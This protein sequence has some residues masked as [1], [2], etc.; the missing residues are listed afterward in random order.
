VKKKIYYLLFTIVLLTTAS[1]IYYTLFHNPSIKSKSAN[2]KTDESSI[3]IDLPYPF[4]NAVSLADDVDGTTWRGDIAVQ[5]ALFDQYGFNIGRSMFMYVP[6]I[7]TNA[8]SFTNQ[9]QALASDSVINWPTYENSTYYLLRRYYDGGINYIHMWSTFEKLKNQTAIIAKQH[10]S[11]DIKDSQH[12]ANKNIKVF[13]DVPSNFP[14]MRL[15]LTVN[16]QVTDAVVQIIDK[17]HQTF[18]WCIGDVKETTSC[19]WRS[20]LPLP[21]TETLKAI[22]FNHDQEKKAT[23]STPYDYKWSTLNFIINGQPGA[24]A[25]FSEVLFSA[26]N[27]NLMKRQTKLLKKLGV[28]FWMYSDHGGADYGVNLMEQALIDGKPEVIYPGNNKN[29]WAQKDESANII[30]TNHP[31]GAQVG[32]D[33]YFADL[34]QKFGSI[35]YLFGNGPADNYKGNIAGWSGYSLSELITP[36]TLPNGRKAYNTHRYYPGGWHE[37]DQGNP[38]TITWNGRFGQALNYIF[39]KINTDNSNLV[40]GP[41]ITHLGFEGTEEKLGLNVHPIK[42]GAPFN[43]T[44]AK[45][46]TELSNRFYNFSN[47]V[48]NTQRIWVTSPSRLYR[49]A[50]IHPA[51]KNHIQVN[52]NSQINITSWTDEVSAEQ[53]PDKNHI[54]RDLAGI[55]VY[56]PDS[57]SATVTV[58]DQD[59]FDFTRNPKDET[60]RES[61][62][63]TDLSTLHIIND[64]VW[65]QKFNN[66]TGS[67]SIKTTPDAPGSGMFL[68]LHAPNIKTPVKLSIPVQAINKNQHA[69]TNFS[70]W[71]KTDNPNAILSVAYLLE[72]GKKFTVLVR[73][74]TTSSLKSP[75]WQLNWGDTNQW[76]RYIVSFSSA[77]FKST[78]PIPPRGMVKAIQLKMLNANT[79]DIAQIAFGRDNPFPGL[80][81]NNL[82][83]G[84]I[85]SLEDEQLVTAH[86]KSQPD[87]QVKT[88]D[89]GYFLLTDIPENTVLTSLDVYLKSENRHVIYNTPLQIQSSIVDLILP[90]TPKTAENVYQKLYKNHLAWQPGLIPRNRFSG[91]RLKSES[92]KPTGQFQVYPANKQTHWAGMGTLQEYDSLQYANNLGFLDRKERFPSPGPD[93]AFN[94]L[95][96]GGCLFAGDQFSAIDPKINDWLE[97]KIQKQLHRP[98]EVP[99]FANTWLNPYSYN[100][101]YEQYGKQ[102]QPK[103]VIVEVMMSTFRNASPYLSAVE[104][105]LQLGAS[106][107]A[108]LDLNKDDSFFVRNADPSFFLKPKKWDLDLHGATAHAMSTLTQP[109]PWMNNELNHSTQII[110]ENLKRM[111]NQIALHGGQLVLVLIQD[112]YALSQ[113]KQGMLG[114]M[115]Y[116][117]NQADKRFS[118]IAKNLDISYLNLV[119]ELEKK[120]DYLQ[121]QWVFDPHWTPKAHEMAADIIMDFLIEKHLL[122]HPLV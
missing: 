15:Y 92:A 107:S 11:I 39:D 105:G 33:Y 89:T 52:Q 78:A 36:Y 117:A 104:N 62:T 25:D 53:L 73:P 54:S 70:F 113:P 16:E 111:K 93:N 34:T 38:Y 10:V 8:V 65:P 68:E 81:K 101:I 23:H 21:N 58:D 91:N 96:F 59:V 116:D 14:G 27:R 112:R 66:T 20:A 28:D 2:K 41:I 74:K 6:K 1:L 5:D 114:Q 85:S 72:N 18:N 9:D 35:Y 7:E 61:I 46:L 97:Q 75:T 77:N 79:V 32:S 122:P 45:A 99:L 3:I 56:V 103:L 63:F 17:N 102:Y 94:V 67:I 31:E 120:P 121:A 88:H 87:V 115:K 44:T 69:E 13:R 108:M 86:F 48:P 119:K 43:P 95:L 64:K 84:R 109:L 82:L 4:K 29:A 50:Q 12:T 57:N 49:Y 42:P 60:G 71:A 90:I 83:L 30:I 19:Q 118:D 47:N 40:Y 110:T 106:R 24:N 98:V 76:R 80:N 26:F 37:K 51:L 55:T 100:L 22:T